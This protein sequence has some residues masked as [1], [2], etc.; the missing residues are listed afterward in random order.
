[1]T[2]ILFLTLG[3]SNKSIPSAGLIK[4]LCGKLYAAGVKSGYGRRAVWLNNSCFLSAKL[5]VLFAKSKKSALCQIYTCALTVCRSLSACAVCLTVCTFHCLHVSV[6]ENVETHITINIFI[7]YFMAVDDILNKHS[8]LMS[9]RTVQQ[10]LIWHN[11]KKSV[12]FFS[13][14]TRQRT[15]T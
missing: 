14:V 13:L 2:L 7:L 10:M 9:D 15:C 5:A 3:I 4:G 1:M 12:E 8:Y 11:E 6:W